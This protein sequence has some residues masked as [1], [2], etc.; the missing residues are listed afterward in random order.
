[1]ATRDAI[2]R[3]LW[4]RAQLRA[5][6]LGFASDCEVHIKQL[7]A[8]AVETLEQQGVTTD[9]DRLAAA[10]QN[11]DIFVREMIVEARA[12]GLDQL[13]ESTYHAARNRLCPLWPLC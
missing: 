7:I 1:M 3:R 6:D 13:H 9:P 4:A 10:E 5:A 11:L 2:E 8:D 12:Q